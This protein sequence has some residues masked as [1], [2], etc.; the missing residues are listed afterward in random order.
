[1]GAGRRAGGRGGVPHEAQARAV[2][3][4]AG[5]VVRVGLAV[6]AAQPHPVGGGRALAQGEA[7]DGVAVRAVALARRGGGR[8]DGQPV[9]VRDHGLVAHGQQ[10]ARGGEAGFAGREGEGGAVAGPARP[11]P[12]ADAHARAP[13]QPPEERLARAPPRGRLPDLRRA[14]GGEALPVAGAFEREARA[15]PV[16]LAQDAVDGG[17]QGHAVFGRAARAG[18]VAGRDL[19]GAAGR[20]RVE[21]AVG[22]VEREARAGGEGAQ[23]PGGL[24][25]A[26]A[27]VQRPRQPRVPDAVGRGRPD[28][29]GVGRGHGQPVSGGGL[30]RLRLGPARG[31]AARERGRMAREDAGAPLRPAV[32]GGEAGALIHAARAEEARP[33]ELAR[34]GGVRFGDRVQPG[35]RPA[36]KPP[37][38]M[39]HDHTCL[40]A[41]ERA[42]PHTI[43]R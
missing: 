30:V 43:R 6:G 27:H 22:D 14:P 24:D 10:A 32:A 38:P 4:D 28:V 18:A 11:A 7:G 13:A 15:R 17:V 33:R 35:Q 9:T 1:M 42:R 39:R 5:E 37:S 36:G 29:G 31:V 21:A 3:G 26:R 25:Y 41:G 20:E 12:A 2:A 34:G 23:P 40:V 8:G 16:R 19:H